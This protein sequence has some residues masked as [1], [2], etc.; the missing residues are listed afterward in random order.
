MY[1]GLNGNHNID[2][3]GYIMY[4]APCCVECF[5]CM[6]FNYC[7]LCDASMVWL[8]SVEGF[9]YSHV[10]VLGMPDITFDKVNNIVTIR[11]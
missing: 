2:M 3:V 11:G 10:H 1:R 9:T 6:F 7:S 8:G 5:R 4:C